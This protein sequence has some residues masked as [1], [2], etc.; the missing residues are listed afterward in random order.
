MHLNFAMDTWE[1]LGFDGEGCPR[2]VTAE[3][4][5]RYAQPLGTIGDID[6]L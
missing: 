5:F 6:W 3:E 4:T 2:T 1:C